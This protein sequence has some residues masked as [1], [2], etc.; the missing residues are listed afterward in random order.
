MQTLK[1][2]NIKLKT[3]NKNIVMNNVKALQE[4]K[5]ENKEYKDALESLKKVNSDTLDDMNVIKLKMASLLTCDYCHEKF[6]EKESLNS[7]I[8]SVHLSH[9]QNRQEEKRIKCKECG[10]PFFTRDDMQRHIIAKHK[11]KFAK[12]T[13]FKKQNEL[14]Q[15]ISEQRLEICGKILKLKQKEIQ[16]VFQCSCRGLCRVNHYKNRWHKSSSDILMEIFSTTLQNTSK[17]QFEATNVTYKSLKHNQCD[18]TVKEKAN[19]GKRT[20]IVHVEKL[21]SI[22]KK[23]NF[24]E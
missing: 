12:E 15:K 17:V 11:E 3:Q 4:L 24:A 14:L 7:H 13:L 9:K 8:D 2:E 6:D 18:Q 19:L 22:L 21:K 23:T 10:K 16:C 5:S 1:N 20:N